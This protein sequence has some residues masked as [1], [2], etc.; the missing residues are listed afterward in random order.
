[1]S[2]TKNN[3]YNYFCKNEKWPKSNFQK[4]KNKHVD[5]IARFKEIIVEQIIK[6]NFIIYGFVASPITTCHVAKT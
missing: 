6:I 3:K 2:F 4:L 1:M 5:I